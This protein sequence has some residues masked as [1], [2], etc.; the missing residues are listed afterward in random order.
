MAKYR[1]T[2]PDGQTFEVTAPD[3]ASE[4]EVAAYAKKNF[5]APGMLNYDELTNSPIQGMSGPERVA[6]GA[7][8][9]V[10]DTA[11]GVGQIVGAVSREDVAATRERDKPLMQTTGGQA[12]N[13]VGQIAQVLAPGGFLKGAGMAAKIAGAGATAERL[14]AAGSTLLVPKTITQGATVGAGFGAVQPSTSTAE[15]V[16][17]VGLGTAAGAVTPVLGTA[18]RAAEPFTE[19]GQ[20]RILGR[21]LN[22]MSGGKGREVAANLRT[23]G[24][25]VPGSVPTYGQAAL[26]PGIAAA[27]RTAVATNPA[28]MVEHSAQMQKQNTS[29]AQVLMDLAGG[30][31]E[32]TMLEEARRTYANQL[33]GKAFKTGIA[34]KKLTPKVTK[35]ISSLMENPY[36]QD[37]LPQAKKMAKADDI[38]IGDKAGS[39][40][41]MHYIKEVLDAQLQNKNPLTAVD[42]NTRRQLTEA[43]E[44]LVFVMQRLSPKYAEAMAEFQAM[45]KPI[46][47]RKIGEEI[48]RRSTS[49]QLDPVTGMPR[50]YPEKMAQTLKDGDKLAQSVTGYKKARM[51]DIL[52]PEQVAQLQ[53]VAADLSRSQAAQNAGRGPGSDTV[54][55]L[56]FREMQDN[57]GGNLLTRFLARVIPGATSLSGVASGARDL[58]YSSPNA[59]MSDLLARMTPAEAAKALDS[60]TEAEKLMVMKTL[61]RGGGGALGYSAPG[62]INAQK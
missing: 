33:Y 25:L 43:K 44:R 51:T 40:E 17:N 47:Q 23:Q 52:E 28:A 32:R 26:N 1:V 59:K 49:A 10:R 24:E 18:A 50:V 2:S 31:E 4:A 55:K 38:D 35:E 48:L 5:S 20:K 46:D 15:T 60:A 21:F 58:L 53:A 3:N 29:R 14:S 37:S 9:S 19:G 30:D 41:G 45:S 11:Q 39:L 12:G 34:E 56:A 13:F 16:T 8:K 54:Q 22:E 57:A 7:F 62:L 6:A 36:I 61:L 27:E 42:R